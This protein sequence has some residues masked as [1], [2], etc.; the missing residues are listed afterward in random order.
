MKKT[1]PKARLREK[2]RT[3]RI[4]KAILFFIFLLSLILWLA[5]YSRTEP[6]K[7]SSIGVSGNSLVSTHILHEI[8]DSASRERFL[9]VFPRDNIVLYPR[10]H[11]RERI[12]REYKSVR[13][14]EISFASARE[15]M[16]TVYEREPA[17]LWCHERPVIDEEGDPE[18]TQRG[19]REGDEKERQKTIDTKTIDQCFFADHTGYI[20]SKAPSFSSNIFLTLRGLVDPTDPIGKTF[21]TPERLESLLEFVDNIETLGASPS[22]LDAISPGDYELHLSPSGRILFN[23]KLG[24]LK[25]FENIEAIVAERSRG[26]REEFFSRLD[27]LDMRIGFKAFLKMK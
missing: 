1:R 5:V 12:L 23:D 17:Y 13:D 16:A 20:F 21:L 3:A 14:I 9:A 2:N 11:V 7:I 24:Y 10:S 6:A 18:E 27:H 19:D 22:T 15:L 4:R 8:L 25:T 26:K